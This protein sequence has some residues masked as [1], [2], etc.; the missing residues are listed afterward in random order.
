VKGQFA[1]IESFLAVSVLSIAVAFFAYTALSS[2]SILSQNRIS[3]SDLVYD[4]PQFVYSNSSIGSCK[5]DSDGC[6]E[7]LGYLLGFYNL[8][9]INFAYQ[10]TNYSDGDALECRNLGRFCIPLKSQGNYTLG[11]LDFCGG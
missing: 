1:I 8:S 6:E 5:P 2:K 4:F 10:G 3:M 11:C 9:Y 7:V